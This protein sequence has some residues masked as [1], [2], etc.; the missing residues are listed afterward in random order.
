ML[1]Q[2]IIIGTVVGTIVSLFFLALFSILTFIEL[3]F[4][5]GLLNY[6]TT[7][8]HWDY[9][10]ACLVTIPLGILLVGGSLSLLFR[11]GEQ[12]EHLSE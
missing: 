8:L 3:A 1:L 10:A 4:I 6:L 12:E 11:G 2:E 9:L 5:F 7:A